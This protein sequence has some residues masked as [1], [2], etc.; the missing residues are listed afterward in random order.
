MIGCVETVSRQVTAGRHGLIRFADSPGVPGAV[1]NL[2]V[3]GN[4][5]LDFA[6][7]SLK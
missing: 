7:P 5:D 6:R 1:V 4:G 3:F 2:R